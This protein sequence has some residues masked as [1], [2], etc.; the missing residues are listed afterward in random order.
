MTRKERKLATDATRECEALIEA[1]DSKQPDDR[2]RFAAGALNALTAFLNEL[3]AREAKGQCAK[4][5]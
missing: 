5:Q 2:D 3:D 1:I 4:P